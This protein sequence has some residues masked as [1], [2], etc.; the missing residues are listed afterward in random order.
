MGKIS[1]A[2]WLF[3][4]DVQNKRAPDDLVYKLSNM[5]KGDITWPVDADTKE[6]VLS[7]IRK[8]YQGMMVGKIEAIHKDTP[9]TVTIDEVGAEMK[10]A[11]DHFLSNHGSTTFAIRTAWDDYEK[12]LA[13]NI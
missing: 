1:F 10:H 4:P 11:I 9:H 12:F 2:A 3:G 5:F 6:Q 13:G 8:K 7:Y